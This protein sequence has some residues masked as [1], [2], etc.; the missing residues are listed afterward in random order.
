MS[1]GEQIKFSA[2]GLERAS[3]LDR[4]IRNQ[5]PEFGRRAVQ[6]LVTSKKV[7]VNG[8]LVWLCSWQVSN[9]DQ[10]EIQAP[11]PKVEEKTASFD[12][13]WLIEK[14]SDVIAVSKPA[15]LL[16]H[17]TR[18]QGSDDIL[19]LAM[20]RFGPV[21]LFHRLDRDTS[22]VMLLTMHGP[23]NRYLDTAFKEGEIEKEYIACIPARNHLDPSGEIKTRMRNHPKRR[24]RMI[25]APH[26]KPAHTNYEILAE[27][28]DRQLIRLWPKTGRTH[29]LRVHMAHLYA[30]IFGDRIYGRGRKQCR[31]LLLH[32]FRI[33]LPDAD[34]FP[35]RIF[36]APIPEDFLVELPDELRQRAEEMNQSL[37]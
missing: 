21:F 16:S 24:D 25:V 17:K 32:A 23:I 11:K 1:K 15:G 20:A 5:V 26:G 3:R 28:E 36:S 13:S 12:D 34:G 4:V 33:T 19:G 9:G 35:E 29:Q 37:K 6:R 27:E 22:G 14:Q 18:A 30:P 31:R 7:R 8:R 10:I 2:K